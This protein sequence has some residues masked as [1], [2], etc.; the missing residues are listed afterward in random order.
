MSGEITDPV[1][2]VNS[3]TDATA[4]NQY[5]VVIGPGEFILTE[6]LFMKPFVNIVGSGMIMTRLTGAIS[7]ENPD[8]YSAIV[9]T[10][11]NAIL[12]DLA[13][14]NT[15]GSYYSIALHNGEEKPLIK[16]VFAKASGGVWS[17]VG[18][19]N[20]IFSSAIMNGVIAIGCGNGSENCYGVVNTW[21]STP[22]M[23][24]VVATAIGGKYK[25]KD[26]IDA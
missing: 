22:T 2:A 5:F 13:I 16:N 25:N 19:L 26:I 9:S 15:G 12:Q 14:E 11:G 17:S 4:E 1:A 24:N 8:A 3:I 10:T 20:D 6:T 23:I 7:S 18:V 21:F